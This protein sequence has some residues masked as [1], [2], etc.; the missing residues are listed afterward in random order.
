MNTDL[1]RYTNGDVAPPRRDR[2][3][4]K[5]GKKVFDDVRLAA[6][7]IDGAFALAAHIMEGAKELDDF[8]S[9]LAQG[10]PIIRALLT[11]IEVTGLRQ[12]AAIQRNV[13]S[14]WNL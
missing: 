7:R 5:N 2:E 1:L 4:A 11:D 8:A 13:Y 3:L 12:A 9:R 6:L 10:D 14:P